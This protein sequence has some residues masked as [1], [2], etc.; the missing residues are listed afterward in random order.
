MKNIL[1]H[2]PVAVAVLLS[3]GI[4]FAQSPAS[5][6]TITQEPAFR[7][8]FVLKL[9]ID[10]ERYYEEHVNR[11]PYVLGNDVYLFAGESFGINVTII[12]NQIARITYRRDPAKGDV[13]S[14][15]HESN[16]Q[17]AR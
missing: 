16:R 14:S 10:S 9:R 5:T 8:P 6:D 15:S 17:T 13:E 12:S 2:A 3:T 1:G 4:A 11:I 7:A